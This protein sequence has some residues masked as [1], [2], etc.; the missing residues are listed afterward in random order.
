[1]RHWYWTSNGCF[2][3]NTALG[4]RVPKQSN[5][6]GGTS[7]ESSL[8]AAWSFA[9][10]LAWV[11]VGNGDSND[12]HSNSG[13]PIDPGWYGDRW[14]NVVQ[15]GDT[16]RSLIYWDGNDAS[17]IGNALHGAGAITG[18]DLRIAALS[19]NVPKE[20]FAPHPDYAMPYSRACALRAG[21]GS[22][23]FPVGSVTSNVLTSNSLPILGGAA[24]LQGAPAVV[25]ASAGS[26]GNFNNPGSDSTKEARLGN[27]IFL[28]STGNRMQQSRAFGNLPWGGGA[29]IFNSAGVNG[30]KRR[31]PGGNGKNWGDFDTGVGDFPDGPFC[32][33]QDEGNVIF[34]YFDSGTN[35]WI[36]PVPYF[37]STWSYQPPG[38]TFTSPSR[39]MPS[40]GM[41][42]SLPSWPTNKGS[43]KGGLG[44]TTLAFSPNPA[45]DEH[46]GNVI[47]PKDHYLLDLFQMPVVEPYPIS[48]PFSTAGKVNL[49]YRIAPFDYIRRSTALRGAL[50]PLRLTAVNSQYLGASNN[51][52]ANANYL[53]YKVGSPAGTPLSQNFRLR[54]D[55]DETIKAFDGFFD[56]GI[57]D[58]TTGFFTSATQVCERFLYSQDNTAMNYA[59]SPSAEATAMRTWW[60]ANGDLTGDNEREKPYVDLYPRVTTKSNTYTV[61]MKVQTLRQS[62][63]HPDQWMEGKDAVLGEYRGSATIERYLDPADTRFNPANTPSYNPDTQSL[64]PLYRF[65][66]VYSRKFTP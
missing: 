24:R 51:S 48:E 47:E 37:T 27:H 29:N 20:E 11:N 40:P 52:N 54:I 18:G 13:N 16:I 60:A 21:D 58:P 12:P 35:Q 55:R 49:N 9:A 41:F 26:G 50:Y 30:V 66:T 10:R 46:P 6:R 4:V 38:N 61:H 33:N 25:Y 17:G 15:P 59:G 34:Q 36:H 22:P 8:Q 7:F 32:N 63:G 64:E 2:F 57:T 14:R 1:M 43:L 23:Y 3:A 56:T 62:P 39:Q 65:R 31:E 42:G 53:T 44:W 28:G 19:A 5:Q 45:G